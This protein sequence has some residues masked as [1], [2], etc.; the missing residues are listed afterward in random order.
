MN[1]SV[2]SRLYKH[3]CCPFKTFLSSVIRIPTPGS[4]HSPRL[5]S[6][7][8]LP[9]SVFCLRVIPFWT[10]HL[11]E[12]QPQAWLFFLSSNC[13][14]G[15][16]MLQCESAPHSSSQGFNTSCLCLYLWIDISVVCPFALCLMPL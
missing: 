9:L 16:S 8:L 15:A 3:Y 11:S 14:H 4:S 12:V 2:F 1:F 10:L 6:Q 13:I 7:S 5:L